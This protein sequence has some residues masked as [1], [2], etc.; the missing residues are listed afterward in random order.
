MGAH[1]NWETGFN[2]PLVLGHIA[3]CRMIDKDGRVSF[4]SH[5]YHFWLPVLESAV[6]ASENATYLKHHCIVQALNDTSLTLKN[7]DAFLQRCEAAHHQLSSRSKSKFIV[8]MSMTYSG[9]PLFA[10][11]TD[12][13][14]SIHWQPK[15]GSKFMRAT[16]KAREGLANVRLNHNVPE[17]PAEI[18]NLLVHVSAYDPFHAHELAADSMDSLRGILNLFINSNRGVNPFSRIGRPHAVNRFRPGPYRTVHNP[19]GSLATDTFWYEHRWLHET[20]TA[21]FKEIDKLKKNLI[22]WWSRLQRN[23]L[24]NHIRHGLLRYC[25]ALDL[26]DAEP[27]LLEMWGALETLTGTQHV[28]YDV[29]IKRTARLFVDRDDAGQVAH[30]VRLRRNSTI[31]AARTLNQQEAD[32][33]LVQAETLVSQV[34]FFCMRDGKR[35]VDKSEL[36]S[37]LDLSLDKTTLKRKVALSKFFVEYQERHVGKS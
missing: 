28:K 29:T 34:L 24:R 35:F 5:E 26:H 10:R 22:E 13:G 21:K 14:A 31:H 12:A 33:I 20:P 3:E 16:H 2:I 23:P 1:F 27:A 11:M 19:D 25:R 32:A 8:V 37:F 15:S 17:E 36:F 30:H 7:S 6:R 9:P 18:T 4:K